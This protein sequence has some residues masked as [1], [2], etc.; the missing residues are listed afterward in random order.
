MIKKEVVTEFENRLD[1]IKTSWK[2]FDKY[3]HILRGKIEYTNNDIDELLAYY[4]QKEKYE[5]CERL[6]KLRK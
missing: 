1:G 5:V 4:T 6:V 2:Y 3:Y